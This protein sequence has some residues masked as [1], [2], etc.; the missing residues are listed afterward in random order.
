[1]VVRCFFSCMDVL[2]FYDFFIASSSAARV[3]VKPCSC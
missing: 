2:C 1:V 3:S